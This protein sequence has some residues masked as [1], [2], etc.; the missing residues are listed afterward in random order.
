M[1][2]LPKYGF[3]GEHID[4]NGNKIFKTDDLELV[5][6]VG[7]KSLYKLVLVFFIAVIAYRCKHNRNGI[8]Q[9]FVQSDSFCQQK[10]SIH[11]GQFNISDFD[12][13]FCFR[14]EK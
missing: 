7:V 1:L 3:F 5:S 12:L 13:V 2:E 10:I 4:K 8:I 14:G 6:I 9:I 11:L